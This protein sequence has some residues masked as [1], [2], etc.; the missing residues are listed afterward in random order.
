MGKF[1]R[2]SCVHPGARGAAFGAP[3]LPTERLDPKRAQ[4]NKP[5]QQKA[6]D[7]RFAV[8]SSIN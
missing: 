8:H 6:S 4:E 1:R 3:D 5:F 7:R 2:L